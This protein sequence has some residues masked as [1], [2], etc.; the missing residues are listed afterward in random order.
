MNNLQSLLNKVNLVLAKE[1]A[2]NKE[3]EL[4]GDNFNIFKILYRQ[5]DE[6]KGHSAFLAELLDEY[7]SHGLGNRFL[8]AFLDELN[9][10]DMDIFTS[11]VKTEYNIGP[12]NKD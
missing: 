2:K 9:I 3:R 1:Q 7:G 12:I 8:S 11:E 10:D 6:V 5:S 4:R